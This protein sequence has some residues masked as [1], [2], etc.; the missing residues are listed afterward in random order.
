MPSILIPL[1]TAADDH[2]TVNAAELADAG[3]AVLSVQKDTTPES[4]AALI[5]ELLA[6]EARLGR[7]SDAARRLAKPH[8]HRVIV[9]ALEELG[10]VVRPHVAQS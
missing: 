3:A 2:Q 6:D 10:G 1:P 5:G 4:L 9:D 8:A 7:M